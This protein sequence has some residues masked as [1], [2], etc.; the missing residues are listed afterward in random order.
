MK[1]VFDEN[2]QNREGV[3]CKLF[4]L[5]EVGTAAA[6]AEMLTDAFGRKYT[7]PIHA[8]ARTQFRVAITHCRAGLGPPV[9]APGHLFS[10]SYGPPF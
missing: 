4:S 1:R 8:S 7:Y 9:V 3:Y 5:R 2:V 6:P 10:T